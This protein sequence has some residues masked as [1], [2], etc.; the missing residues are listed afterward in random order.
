MTPV[1]RLDVPR[2][3]PA[4]LGMARE[5][6]VSDLHEVLSA[7]LRAA[8]TM[9]DRMRPLMLGV[10]MAGT[11]AFPVEPALCQMGGPGCRTNSRTE[12]ISRA[13]A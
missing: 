12:N 5:C 7:E 2:L 10:R 8:A 11:G 3:D 9:S 6:A 1:V 4:I 13:F